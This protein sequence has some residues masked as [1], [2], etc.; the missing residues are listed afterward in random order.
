MNKLCPSCEMVLDVSNFNKN[1]NA[2]D[3]L[4]SKCRECVN[5]TRRVDMTPENKHYYVSS[6]YEY[7]DAEQVDDDEI[8]A[9]VDAVNLTLDAALD[10]QMEQIQCVCAPHDDMPVVRRSVTMWW[11]PINNVMTMR[12]RSNDTKFLITRVEM[13]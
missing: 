12:H 13:M 5:A 2:N 6:T 3:G 10:Y 7:P 11:D 9:Q 4:Q 8:T 1:A